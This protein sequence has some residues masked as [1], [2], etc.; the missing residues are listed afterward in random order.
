EELEGGKQTANHQLVDQLYTTRRLVQTVSLIIQ[1]MDRF[2]SLTHTLEDKSKIIVLITQY[3]KT[4]L[5]QEI[6][7]QEV[8]D[9]FYISS[10]YLSRLFKE[11]SSMSFTEFVL[12][13]KTELAIVMM[14]NGKSLTEI[15]EKLGYLNLSSFTRMFKKV[16]GASP[17]RYL[18]SV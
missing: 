8:A 17:S 15:S 7:L 9:T 1:E 14:K 10:N 16:R 12:Y 18:D 6:T 2:S 11:V 3:I 13:E 4:H 5:Q